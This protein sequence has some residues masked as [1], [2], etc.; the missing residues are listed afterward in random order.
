MHHSSQIIVNLKRPAF[1]FFSFL[2]CFSYGLCNHE[3]FYRSHHKP[4]DSPQMSRGACVQWQAELQPAGCEEERWT[5]P[6]QTYGAVGQADVFWG[7]LVVVWRRR[8]CSSQRDE[9]RKMK[10]CGWRWS[11]CLSRALPLIWPVRT[12]EDDPTCFYLFHLLPTRVAV[13]TV[14]T[15]SLLFLVYIR[16]RPQKL[17]ITEIGF[18]RLQLTVSLLESS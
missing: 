5:V 4:A 6:V 16:R 7:I 14:S 12:S 13:Y 8:T 17:I 2:L 11:C 3:F 1:F 18:M 9:Q 15:D 10:R